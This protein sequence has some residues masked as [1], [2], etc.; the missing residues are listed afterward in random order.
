[1]R[2]IRLNGPGGPKDLLL[3]EIDVPAIRAGEALV[4]VYAAAIT[5][6][7]LDWPTDR[8]PAIPSYE[9]SGVV[10]AVAP[11]VDEFA[12]GD[13]VFGMTPFDRDGVAAE[14]AVVPANVLAPKP[15]TLDHV[16]SAVIP[17]PGLSAW[18]GLF[19]HGGMQAGERVL[20][21]GASGGVGHLAVQ[22]A[23]VHGAEL[24]SD[25]VDLVF[26]TS[27]GETLARPADALRPGGRLVSVAEEPAEGTY[28]LVETNRAQLD[29]LA[30]LAD[31][32]ELRPEI[33]SVFPLEE[34][35]AAFER[36][37]ARGKRGKVVLRIP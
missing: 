24:A 8:L 33:D 35:Q 31:D 9:L 21:T 34:A 7:E 18:Q 20:I 22:L 11:D 1:M 3:E 13:E 26:D 15:R 19:D 4:R 36:S 17:L 30:R 2:A 37:M 23:R 10:D 32:H 5:R 14:F 25:G 28:Y 12:V 16:Q 27:G 6:D 29:E